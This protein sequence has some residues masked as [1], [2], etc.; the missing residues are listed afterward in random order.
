MSNGMI[1][2][3]IARRHVHSR[4]DSGT[5]LNSEPPYWQ[6]LICRTKMRPMTMRNPRFLVMLC[7]RLKLGVR[8][9]KALNV[10]IKM[11]KEKKAVRKTGPP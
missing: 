6:K 9:L 2:M 8:T 5:V 4:N 3:L 1:V 10:Q 11:K 7:P